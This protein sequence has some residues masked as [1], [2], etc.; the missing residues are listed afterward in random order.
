[1]RQ[2]HYGTT[3]AASNNRGTPIFTDQ[4]YAAY[5][6]LVTLATP[7]T[8]A[9]PLATGSEFTGPP[10]MTMVVGTT[11]MVVD[12]VLQA[13]GVLSDVVTVVD[14]WSW[15]DVCTLMMVLLV[16]CVRTVDETMV[17]TEV[18]CGIMMA[19]PAGGMCVLVSNNN[20]NFDS[21]TT[22]KNTGGREITVG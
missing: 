5:G 11:K 18:I 10:P 15:V 14:T 1:M 17:A 6:L 12:V 20:H 3:I 4:A 8:I 22:S 16:I 7:A 13:G 19:A 9:L 2:Q 21:T